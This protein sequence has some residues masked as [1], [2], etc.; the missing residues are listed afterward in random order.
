MGGARIKIT[1][2]F[3]VLNTSVPAV[4]FL[5][6]MVVAVVVPVVWAVR[7]RQRR[8][9]R[10][11]RHVERFRR[12]AGGAAHTPRPD[13]SPIEMTSSSLESIE[14]LDRLRHRVE[15]K[16][17]VNRPGSPAHPA[18]PPWHPGSRLRALNRTVR[19]ARRHR[20]WVS[21]AATGP[22]VRVLGRVRVDGFGAALTSQQQALVA[23]LGLRGPCSRDQIIDGIWSGRAVSSSRFANLLADI[24]AV[25]GRD[26]LV[27]NPDGR[28][29]LVG[30][31]VD[32]DRFAGLIERAVTSSESP[33]DPGVQAALEQ[34]EQ[35]IGLI[36]GP[37]LDSGHRRFWDWVDDGY[38]RRY[39]M[40][41]LVV[42][43]GLRAAVLALAA[44]QPQR[45][46]WACERCLAGVPHDERLV[47]TLTEIHL[48]QGRRGAAA[49]VVA[50]W[51]RTIRRLGLGEPSPHPRNL[52]MAGPDHSTV[53]S[54]A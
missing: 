41:R 18:P 8:N 6:M 23:M 26:R 5:S 53:A 36:D 30:V 54:S 31:D 19:L 7:G 17:S 37:I 33:D 52:L 32:V 12:D 10:A 39:E 21:D 3:K 13:D 40:E 51:E 15:A 24:R 28:Y 20:P 35:A 43:A 38:H 14:A 29:E 48:V 16:E 34:L 42:S 47:A 25:V 4:L 46:R 9:S 44:H 1:G 45:A 22:L 49:E 27:Q 2:G 50:G 11:R